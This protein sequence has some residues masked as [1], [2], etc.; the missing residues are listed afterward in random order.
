MNLAGSVANIVPRSRH[1]SMIDTGDSMLNKIT[2]RKRHMSMQDRVEM[3]NT[4]IALEEEA[5]VDTTAVAGAKSRVRKTSKV[6]FGPPDL[7]QLTDDD[8]TDN[9]DAAAADVNNVT[10]EIH[11]VGELILRIDNVL[12]NEILDSSSNSSESEESFQ[13]F[14]V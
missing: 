5:G 10:A 14:F 4:V 3:Y 7:S 9:T 13:S 12:L 2:G 6:M 1:N 11:Q 8:N